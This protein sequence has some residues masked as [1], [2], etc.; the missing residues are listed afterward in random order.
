M[1]GLGVYHCPECDAPFLTRE[2]RDGHKS[3]AHNGGG[4]R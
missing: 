2:A 4:Q 3:T 1:S